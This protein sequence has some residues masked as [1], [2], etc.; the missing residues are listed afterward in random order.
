MPIDIDT[1]LAEWT[2]ED[3]GWIIVGPSDRE[4]WWPHDQ[5]PGT[6][7]FPIFMSENDALEMIARIPSDSAAK[8]YPLRVKK[9]RLLNHAQI[10]AERK[11]NGE[12]VGFVVL[13]P[14]EVF[15][16]L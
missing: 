2:D 12:P 16:F 3:P 6:E 10:I 7:V 15:D 1:L 4:L 5:Y 13:S 9:V 8:Q 11:K 14:N